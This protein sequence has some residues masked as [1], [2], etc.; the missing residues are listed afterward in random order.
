MFDKAVSPASVCW[1]MSADPDTGIQQDFLAI[2]FFGVPHVT[3]EQW[4][5]ISFDAAQ[6][7]QLPKAQSRR[8]VVL[9]ECSLSNC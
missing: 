9:C 1:L 5:N 2:C 4:L 8:I 7:V 6:T 3:T